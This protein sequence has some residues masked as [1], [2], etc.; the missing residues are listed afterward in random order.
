MPRMQAFLAGAIVCAFATSV[1][2][3]PRTRP[4]TPRPPERY[5]TVLNRLAAMGTQAV[6]AWR[7]HAA[8]GIPHGEDAALD[9]SQWAAIT[10]TGGRGGGGGNNAAPAP[11]NG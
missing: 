6:S 1:D 11:G 4:Q 7:V 5:A 2:A 10:L 8:D 3:Q 9:D